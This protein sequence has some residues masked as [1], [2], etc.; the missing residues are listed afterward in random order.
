[1]RKMIFVS[2]LI[3]FFGCNSSVSKNEK[4]SD[5]ESMNLKT[6]F[7]DLNNKKVNL[8]SYK[9]KKIIQYGKEP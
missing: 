5:I 1:M 3:L 6:S 4:L 2:C 9:G 8:T 7:V